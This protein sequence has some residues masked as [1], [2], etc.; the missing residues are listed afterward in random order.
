[1]RWG[2]MREPSLEGRERA[3]AHGQKIQEN[4]VMQEELDLHHAHA[5][6]I[7]GKGWTMIVW[8]GL[9]LMGSTRL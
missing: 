1:M 2:W 3:G 4:Q 6:E 5:D 9:A 7:R 8:I